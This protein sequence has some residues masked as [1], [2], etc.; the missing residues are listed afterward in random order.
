MCKKKAKHTSEIIA[1]TKRTGKNCKRSTWVADGCETSAWTV[2]QFAVKAVEKI[3]RIKGEQATLSTSHWL[4][5]DSCSDGRLSSLAN[6]GCHGLKMPTIGSSC[7]PR[8]HA[9]MTKGVKHRWKIRTR[10]ARK[11]DRITRVRWKIVFPPST[12]LAGHCAIP[13]SL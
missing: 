4:F 7:A 2:S 3:P 9:V 10:R 12:S 5:R 13:R 8:R 1:R 11:N 6:D